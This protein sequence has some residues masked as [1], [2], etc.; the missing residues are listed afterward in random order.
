MREDRTFLEK[1]ATG[2]P[3]RSPREEDARR[4]RDSL[5]AA[6]LLAFFLHLLL[7]WA[8]PRELFEDPPEQVLIPQSMEIILEQI[9]EQPE[10]Q[11]TYVR[12]APD[13][14]E[15]IP[16]ETLNISDRNQVAAQ[17]ESVAAISPDNTP[18]VEGD[19]EDSNRLVQ[20]NP[21]QEPTPPAPPAASPTSATSP[22]VQQEA[23]PKEIPVQVD[24]DY[25]EQKPEQDEGI[26]SIEN[27]SEAQET[28]EEPTEPLEEVLVTS[29]VDG[30]GQA[31]MTTPAQA[32]QQPNPVPRPRQRVERDTSYGPIKDNR[33]GAI[34]IG[35][36]AFDARYS[37]FGE[38]WRRVAEIIEARWRN[39]V[40]NT[41]A[42]PRN[43][44]KVVVQFSITRDGQ[45]TDVKV[46]V[47]SAG[48][49]ANTI[50]V[51]AILGQSPYDEWTPEMIVKMGEKAECAIHFYY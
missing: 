7:F 13:V 51:D 23:A 48:K 34:V 49:L 2:K 33:Q 41:R 28:P 17:E 20:G 42:I 9:P 40:Y 25:I 36:L 12:A 4:N 8:T 35:R 3:K 39:L 50:S 1:P 24:P 18:Y 11:E 31:E 19:E 15:R 46:P 38:Y 14:E 21:N 29:K 44:G 43:G 6:I 10:V 26:A 22:V 16:E 45:V 47:S 37:E 32:A 27:P 30:K 5:F